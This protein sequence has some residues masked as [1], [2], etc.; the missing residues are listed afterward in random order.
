MQRII[1]GI[2]DYLV[3]HKAMAFVAL[4]V[5]IVVELLLSLRIGYKENV[6]D[7]LPKDEDGRR[8]MSVYESMAGQNRITVIFR[9]KE[10]S[11]ALAIQDA[12]EN[13]ETICDSLAQERCEEIVLKCHVDESSALDAM[14]FIRGN[15]ALFLNEDDYD[16]MESLL[17]KPYYVDSCL[18]NVRRLLSFPMGAIAQE[19]IAAD[20][21]NLF[22]PALRRLDGLG[23]SSNFEV[24]DE[25][26]FDIDGNGYAFVESPYEGNDT[27]GN[28]KI[29]KLL[30]DAMN[31]TMAL[32]EDV[33]ISAV[34]A[35]LI[36]VGNASQIKKDSFF[37]MLLSI[38]LISII[39]LVAIKRKR[40]ILLLGVSV[41][42]GWLFALAAV[43]ILS[44]TVSVIV[45]GI[46][47][48]LIGIAVNYPLHFLEHLEEHPDRR[49]TLKE[50][51]E[52]LVT[53]NITTVSAFACLVF[54]DSD[55]MRDLG[56]FG[57]LMLVGTILFVMI[58]LPLMA[59]GGRKNLKEQ[60][61]EA[62]P[63]V[64]SRD[65]IMDSRLFKSVTALSVLALTIWLGIRSMNPA[66]D[67]DLHNINY[68]T[69]GQKEDLALLSSAMGDTS[70][71]V[72]YLVSC[73]KTLDEALRQQER[74]K[75]G[76]YGGAYG[77]LPST[78]A[79]R[80]RI[81][82]WHEFKERH[83]NLAEEVKS[84]ALR[85]GF[86]S[87]AFE[88]FER[89]LES[90]YS[91]V[92]PAEMGALTDLAGNYIMYDSGEVRVVALANVDAEEAQAFKEK[93]RK[94]YGTA[95]YVFDQNDVGNNLVKSLNVDFNYLLYL[96][97]FVVFVFLWLSFRQIELA[98]LS[99]LPLAV[100]WLWILGI[101]DIASVKFNI[102]NVILATFIFGQGDDYT[103]FIT[104]GLVFENTYGK[105]RLKS[106]R[107]SVIVSAL[108]M[109]A[110]IGTLIFAKHHAMRSLAEVAIIGM[111]VVVL[112]AC[113]LPPL[114]FR[115]LTEKGGR[116]RDV[117]ITLMRLLRTFVILLVFIVAALVV[118]TPYTFIYRLIG[119][120]SERK[121][122]R[123]HRMIQNFN[124][125]A[126]RHLPGVKFRMEKNG[127][128]FSKPAVIVANHHSHLDLLCMLQ[129]TPRLVILTNDWVW[130]NPVY[131][132]IIR[133]AEFYPVHDGYETL[134]PKLRSLVE[135]GYSIVV[136]PEGTRSETG[137]IGRFHKG[138]FLL[139][140]ELGVDLLP[141]YLHGGSDV[142]PKKDII[143]RE[144]Q[145]SVE[146][147]SRVC[148]EQF[149]DK[150]TL[151]LT[152]EMHASFVDH[153]EE[154][155]E[156]IEDEDYRRPKE[157][158]D[159]LYKFRT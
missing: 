58:I 12:V 44:T 20:P 13:F 124:G 53:G 27:K 119:R 88:P 121:R 74:L 73:G 68:M 115:W 48:V 112:M 111:A 143:L 102:V 87:D 128:D 21:L 42:A 65:G 156:R 114:V 4:G 78:E 6:S 99:F 67:D 139:A 125:I 1:V 33:R 135:R 152:K 19:A 55:A 8:Y 72:E 41:A 36:A 82:L 148:S 113:Y 17:E 75:D 29:A 98:L 127:E 100:A 51:V 14:A 63:E 40:N 24:D 116:K 7:F 85:R 84:K 157:K 18:D 50:M 150:E 108:L 130:R 66:F 92:D 43:S 154:M 95:G 105:R 138:A 35:P 15:I 3:R 122:L 126:V 16:R 61:D 142:M 37:A 147:G 69:D 77:I 136:F 80:E 118:I 91:P 70:H 52:P 110:G 140:Q 106:Y 93:T 146:V 79:Q 28:S 5:I 149:K 141:V 39:L 2:Y 94:V 34:G 132:A 97:G 83:G 86:A 103:I 151:Q 133:Y 62:M 30:D 145:L 158:Y 9:N 47:S 45:I 49:E 26:L 56:L 31:Q 134:A 96:C 10:D 131:G 76:V 46:G 22:S 64:R 71:C 123:F 120:D 159:R 155:R 81:K 60:E 101:M 11:D 104:E 32:N 129:L 59:K 23:P 54:M 117:P 107:R 38:V 25:V 153:Y 137:A 89:R 109:F 57:S 144:G 90:D